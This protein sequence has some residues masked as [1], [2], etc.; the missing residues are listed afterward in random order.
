MTNFNAS[1]MLPLLAAVAAA[2]VLLP[3]GAAFFWRRRSRAPWTPLLVGGLTF[4]LA[5]QVLEALFHGLCLQFITPVADF[6]KAHPI[7]YAFYGALAAGVFEETGRWVAFRYPLRRYSAR[8]TAISY[9]LGHGGMECL[10]VLAVTYILYLAVILT[11]SPMMAQLG[12]I[13]EGITPF[14]CLM[15]V[16]ERIMAMIFHVSAS[17]WVFTAVHDPA[18]RHFYPLAI[19]FHALLDLPA[20]FYQIAN[21]NLLTVE[22]L[23]TVFVLA[24]AFFTR[25]L[26]AR[27]PKAL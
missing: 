11:G 20:V 1:S 4:F 10:L 19:L 24:F 9:G 3:V 14:Y 6:L 23:I 25:R 12:P 13:L 7:V 2:A 18:R 8:E 21:L 22:A 15:A 17:V 16:W 5:V 26:Y 27:L